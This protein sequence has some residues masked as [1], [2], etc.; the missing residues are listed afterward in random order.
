MLYVDASNEPA[1]KL[2]RDVG[3]T[4]DHIDRAYVVDV[5]AASVPTASGGA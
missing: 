3:F 1:V 5:P 2:Y 4:V